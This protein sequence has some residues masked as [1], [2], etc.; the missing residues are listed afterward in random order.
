MGAGSDVGAAI[1]PEPVIS[2]ELASDVSF[3]LTVSDKAAPLTAGFSPL[4]LFFSFAHA[5]IIN[6]SAINISSKDFFINSSLRT[7]N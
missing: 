5:D 4:S 7:R 6:S 3:S 2:D 1:S